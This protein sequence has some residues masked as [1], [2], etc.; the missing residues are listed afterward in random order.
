MRKLHASLLSWLQKNPDNLAQANSSGGKKDPKNWGGHLKRF[1]TWLIELIAFR[2]LLRTCDVVDLTVENLGFSPLENDKTHISITPWWTKTQQARRVKPF[3]FYSEYFDDMVD[4]CIVRGF[5]AW[6][7]MS[8][9]TK[10]YLCPKIY[11]YDQLQDSMSDH[12][13]NF[14]FRRLNI[15]HID[16]TSP[17]SIIYK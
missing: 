10:G 17:L 11:G 13:Y 9:I 3:H 16:S 8:G 2:C 15:S 7:H 12:M 1:S 6:M 14:T 4:L 5:R